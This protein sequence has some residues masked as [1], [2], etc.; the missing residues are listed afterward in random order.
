[1]AKVSVERAVL[2]QSI[3]LCNRSIQQYK[4]T[5]HSLEMKYREAGGNW[6]DEKYRQLGG[7]VNE[8]ITALNAPQK[9]MEECL[10]KLNELLK[11]IESYE[12][13]NL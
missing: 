9:E 10:D 2:V 13:E 7:V 8:C 3:A 1:M 11:A 12:R 4:Q 6:H 5:S